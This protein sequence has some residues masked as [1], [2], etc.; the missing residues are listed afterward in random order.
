MSEEL[1]S[2]SKYSDVKNS[3]VN[4]SSFHIISPMNYYFTIRLYN[5]KIA[6]PLYLV[7]VFNC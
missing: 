5:K 2:I 1:N 3:T 4:L 7:E 6:L